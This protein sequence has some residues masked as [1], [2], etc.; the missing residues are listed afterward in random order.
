VERIERLHV[1]QLICAQ[2]AL[3]QGRVAQVNERVPERFPAMPAGDRCGLQGDIVGINRLRSNHHEVFSLGRSAF[4]KN[5]SEVKEH[6]CF[7][8]RRGQEGRH[9]T[10]FVCSGVD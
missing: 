5:V 10:R 3:A 4:C 7:R 1:V 2:K 9:R 8:G 6:E